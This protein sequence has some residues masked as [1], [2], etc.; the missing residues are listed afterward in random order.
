MTNKLL[1]II[2]PHYNSLDTLPKLITSIPERDDI[3]VVIVDDGSD[4]SVEY[5]R[6][7]IKPFSENRNIIVVKNETGVKGPGGARNMGLDTAKGEFLLFADSDDAFV[8]DFYTA[9]SRY[10]DGDADIVYFSPTG[11]N[12]DTGKPSTRHLRYVDVV[13]KCADK[14]SLRT[15]TELKYSFCTPWSK[16]YRASIIRDNKIRYGNMMVSEDNYFTVQAARYAKKIIA[17]KTV[18]YCVTRSSGTLSSTKREADYDTRI[19]VLIWRYNYLKNN[20]SKK[21]FSYTNTEWLALAKLVDS[22]F[23]GWGIKKFFSVLSKYRKGN[24]KVFNIGLLNP[25]NIKRNIEIELKLWGEIKKK[26]K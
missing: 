5:I 24:V 20:L 14:P 13:E 16:L 2:I 10:F 3:E 8:G 17:D 1:S 15:E 18:I 12:A 21:E 9:V 6:E 4:V 11:I 26:G 25:V 22:L 23:D 7:Y 19:D